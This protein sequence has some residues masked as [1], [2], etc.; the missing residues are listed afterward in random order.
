M[1]SPS[2]AQREPIEAEESLLPTAML[3]AGFLVVFALKMFG[4]GGGVSP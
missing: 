3:F 1:T 4:R 2:G